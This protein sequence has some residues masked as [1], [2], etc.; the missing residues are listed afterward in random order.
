VSERDKHT[1]TGWLIGVATTVALSIA[2]YTLTTEIG[3]GK[4]L[5]T[6]TQK[7]KQNVDE[8]CQFQQNIRDLKDENSKQHDEIK[9]DIK[10][11]KADIKLLLS[12]KQ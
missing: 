12:R 10:E 1:L 2:A 8:H 3:Y 4:E 11:I 6:S 5:A 7:H 9:L